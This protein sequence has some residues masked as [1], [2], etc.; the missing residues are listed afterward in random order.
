MSPGC[1]ESATA[2]VLSSFFRRLEEF[3]AVV[4]IVLCEARMGIEITI[5]NGT[6]QR[7]LLDFGRTPP[8]VFVDRTT[9]GAQVRVAAD[10]VTLH[11]VLLGRVH[12]AV[13]VG[14]RQ[15]LLRGSIADLT[16]LIPLFDLSPILYREHLADLGV[17]GFARPISAKKENLMQE[18]ASD[19]AVPVRKAPAFQKI[20]FRSLNG[21]AYALGY[22][23]GTLR[24][25][26]FTNL[27]LFE[28][29]SAMSR[30][31]EAATPRK[32]RDES[33]PGSAGRFR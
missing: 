28:I 18:D 21:A 14:R 10:A 31:L 13:A 23:M 6:E 26:V 27:S 16:H 29:L 25:R 20:L 22:L 33:G 19:R 30:G 24:H 17:A 5:R 11:D 12:A 15:L 3:G 2:T 4:K 32:N 1:E 7:V 9:H 8:R